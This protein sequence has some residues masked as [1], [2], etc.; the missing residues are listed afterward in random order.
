MQNFNILNKTILFCAKRN[1]GKSQLVRYLV[2]SQ[3]ADFKKI[4]VICPTE[5]I[6]RFYGDIVPKDCIFDIYNDEWVD[7]LI[8]RMTEIN[9]GLKSDKAKHILLILD[10]CISDVDFHH[11]KGINKLFSRG[12]HLFISTMV[13]TQYI[14][15]VPPIVRNNSDYIFCGQMNSKSIDILADEF[16]SGDLAK[17]EFIKLYNQSTKDYKFMVINNNSVK[18]NGDLNEIYGI[19]KVP[20]HYLKK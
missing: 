4:F 9:A 20:E 2:S 14:N 7:K 15:S 12:R 10:D 19:L 5:P 11:S 6:N 16:L 13:I 3:Y 17:P 8:K 18:D 1:S